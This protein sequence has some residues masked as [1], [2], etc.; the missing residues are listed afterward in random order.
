MNQRGREVPNQII[1]ERGHLPSRELVSQRIYGLV[2][3]QMVWTQTPPRGSSTTA[4]NARLTL[5]ALRMMKS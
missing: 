3:G 2:L 5:Q 4:H 1:S